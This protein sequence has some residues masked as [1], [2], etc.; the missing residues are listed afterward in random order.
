MDDLLA[1]ADAIRPYKKQKTK[2]EG[3]GFKKHTGRKEVELDSTA[4]SILPHTFVP[5][6]LRSGSPPPKEAKKYTHISDKKL[7]AELSRQSVHSTRSKALL[8]DAAFLLEHE[9]SGTMEVEGE[10]ER[11]WR[12]GQNEICESAGQEA[13][14][15]RREWKLDGGP[16]R[17]RYTRNG[18]Y[19]RPFSP[20]FSLPNSSP[21][22]RHLA[23]VGVKGH[24]ATFDWQTGTLHS[25]LQ[26]R[27]TCR[28]ITFVFQKLTLDFG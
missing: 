21:S 15:G 23:I 22:P 13:A 19:M 7:R 9:E 16:Y 24:V 27:E 17:S 4:R 18:R 5:K 14:K 25:E 12:V 11:T 10:L 26:L 6:S 8:E 1:K 20:T 3:S 28:D 2:S